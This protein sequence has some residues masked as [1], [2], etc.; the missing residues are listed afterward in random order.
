[1][2]ESGVITLK[3][4]FLVY[5]SKKTGYGHYFRS[6]ALAQTAQQ[7]GHDVTIAGDRRPSNSLPFIHL[8]DLSPGALVM[9]LQAT[10]PD[11][12]IVDL[13]GDL[14]EW[15]RELTTCK[16]AVL[17][18]IGY[19][20]NEEGLDLRVIQGSRDVELPGEQ[21]NVPTI[22]G[23]EYVILRPEIARYKDVVKTPDV[24]VWAG[25]S[26]AMGLLSRFVTVCPGWFA[27]L[28]VSP[29]SP[30][31]L[32]ISPTHTR[33]RPNPDTDEMLEWLAG[34]QRAVVAMG[35][36]IYEAIWLGVKVHCFNAT[37]LHLAFSRPLDKLGLLKS[38]PA[39][40]LPTKGE[41]RAFLE[42][43]FELLKETGL[44]LLGSQRVMEAIEKY[45]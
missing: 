25:G 22:R 23:I 43:D 4:L 44:D 28:V 39:V 38:Y 26:D 7:R 12:L 32:V 45:G 35:M 31:P 18:G 36:I 37:K 24:L 3:L 9:A 13:P 33:I 21:D 6:L 17:N 27:T 11:W 2:G 41:M 30:T 29:M 10:N 20:Q 15:I 8:H 16:I 14:P 34:S 40:G 5:C 42:E 19:N 1:M